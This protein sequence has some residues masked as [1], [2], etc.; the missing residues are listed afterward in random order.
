MGFADPALDATLDHLAA[1]G[2]PAARHAIA[3]EAA[4]MLN[5]GL[6]LVPL[7]T[8]EWHVGHSARLAGYRPWPSDYHILHAGIL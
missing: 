1:A 6:P 2:A 5:A 4:A 7:L 3:R 8:P